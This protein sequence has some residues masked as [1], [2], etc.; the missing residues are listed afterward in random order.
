MVLASWKNSLDVDM[1]NSKFALQAEITL[2]AYWTPV[3]PE[4]TRFGT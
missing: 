4:S 3:G 1:S 2:T